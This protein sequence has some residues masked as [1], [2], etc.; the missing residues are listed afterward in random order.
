MPA[1]TGDLYAATGVF[2]ALAAILLFIRDDAAAGRVSATFG[3][4][5]VHD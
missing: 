4:E 3:I 2:A 5:V 1:V